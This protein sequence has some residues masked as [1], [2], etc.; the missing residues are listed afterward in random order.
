MKPEHKLKTLTM[1]IRFISDTIM[2]S[3]AI[4]IALHKICTLHI[5]I[6]EKENNYIMDCD[7]FYPDLSTLN[8][9]DCIH[10]QFLTGINHSSKLN[11]LH[12]VLATIVVQQPWDVY[13]GC[14]FYPS[15]QKISSIVV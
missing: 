14:L 15:P 8:F 12:H 13:C 4:P 10:F 7:S 3:V 9:L 5:S 11:Q 1:L 6:G 2:F